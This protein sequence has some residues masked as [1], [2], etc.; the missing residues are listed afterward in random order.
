MMLESL[1]LAEL[2]EAQSGSA[3]ANTGT[4]DGESAEAAPQS[5]PE[6][7]GGR[8]PLS[9][10]GKVADLKKVMTDFAGGKADLSDLP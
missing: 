9:D 8:N 7:I 4:A 3:S 5:A 6:R 1:F 10:S 2:D